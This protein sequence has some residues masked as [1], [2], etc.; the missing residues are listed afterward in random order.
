M[1]YRFGMMLLIMMV[2]FGIVITFANTVFDYVKVREM[3]IEQNL[4][5]VRQ[6]EISATNAIETIEK[7]YSL[8]GYHIANSMEAYS[9]DLLQ[10]YEEQPLFDAWDFADLKSK[11]GF[12]IYII[13]DR[14]VIVHS[15]YLDDIGLDFSACCPKFA[16]TLDERRLTGQFYHDGIDI[17]QNTGK[18]KK[19]SYLGTPDQRYLIQLGYEL[20]EDEILQHFDFVEA[21]ET[22]V[23]QSPSVYEINVF[24]RGGY[25]L[26]GT[27]PLELS[28]E[29]RSHFRQTLRTGE[30]VELEGEWNGQSAIY[31]YVRYI[32]KYENGPSQTKVLEIV[33][34]DEN[35]QAFLD[36]NQIIF[37][38]QMA[39]I[40]VVG[41]VIAYVVSRWVAKPLHLAFHDSLTGLNN[42]AA[43][44]ELFVR[45]LRKSPQ[46]AAV[47]MIDLD[48]FKLVN[49]R[50]GHDRGDQLLRDVAQVVSHVIR[51]QD[52]A[53]RLGGD[54]FAVLMPAAGRAEATQVAKQVI[55]A[56]RELTHEAGVQEQAEVTVSIGVSLYPEHGIDQE[57]LLKRADEALYRSKENG[58]NQM[59]VYSG[60]EAE[61]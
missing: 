40:L 26:E 60:A 27:A 35:L 39:L 58:K 41:A 22:F 30:T 34:T 21:I 14:N 37:I 9:Y 20:E 7:A 48:N 23:Q 51:K 16:Q 52:V 33:Y 32:S 24:N 59:Q 13:N 55:E 42:R 11:L 10:L 15:S 47:M 1:R 3:A 29:R 5:H 18:L 54:E 56:I 12:D 57:T 46:T 25:L 50:L 53:I 17:E 61:L 36:D 6:I 31:R 28:E 19:Y 8:F 45:L 4:N 44:D 49:D 38:T 43:M 2:V